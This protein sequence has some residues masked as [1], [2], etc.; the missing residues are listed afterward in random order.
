MTHNKTMNHTLLSGMKSYT[1]LDRF[2]N[3][4][5][6]WNGM[7]WGEVFYGYGR[8]KQSNLNLHLASI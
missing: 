7:E 2:S 4:R 6:E 1:A 3:N 8:E 5:T